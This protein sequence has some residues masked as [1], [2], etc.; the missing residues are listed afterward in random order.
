[1]R[2]V[3]GRA[4][5]GLKDL[6]GIRI[7]SKILGPA[8]R[9]CLPTFAYGFLEFE[10]AGGRIAASSNQHSTT[11]I[12]GLCGYALDFMF[13]RTHHDSHVLHLASGGDPVW[14]FGD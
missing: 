8:M 2:K 6:A 14:I 11:G 12:C 1:M 4:I 10:A 13:L 3:D 9:Q 5:S 7:P